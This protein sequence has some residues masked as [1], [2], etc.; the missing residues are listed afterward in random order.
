MPSMLA[1]DVAATCFVLAFL[2]TGLSI[3]CAVFGSH[4]RYS[5]SALVSE[6]AAFVGLGCLLIVLVALRLVATA[7]APAIQ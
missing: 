3:L 4:R 6:A 7:S 1:A 5:A 2:A